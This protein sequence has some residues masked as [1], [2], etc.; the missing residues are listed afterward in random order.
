MAEAGITVTPT[1][2]VLLAFVGIVHTGVGY[3]LYFSGM[4]ELPAQT[5][6]VLSYIDPVTAMI[7]SGLV[8]GETMTPAQMAGA[9]LILGMTW[10]GSRPDSRENGI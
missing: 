5:V 6:A 8:L 10:L 9:V 1:A 2:W 7:L 4:K 3:L